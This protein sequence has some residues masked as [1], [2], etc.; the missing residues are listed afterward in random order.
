MTTPRQDDV[1]LALGGWTRLEGWPPSRRELA[2]ALGIGVSTVQRHL[3]R[4][5]AEGLIER[6][7]GK[8]RTLRFTP[9][10]AARYWALKEPSQ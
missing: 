2:E 10:G 4:L 1:L 7:P 8:P 6:K 9:A 3:D 5:E